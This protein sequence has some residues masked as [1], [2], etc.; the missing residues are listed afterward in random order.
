MGRELKLLARL[1]GDRPFDVLFEYQNIRPWEILRFFDDTI[2]GRN[3]AEAMLSNL[4]FSEGFQLFTAQLVPFLVLWLFCARAGRGPGL[5]PRDERWF[6]G[7]VVAGTAAVIAFKPVY[8]LVYVAFDRVAQDRG[9]VEGH[10]AADLALVERLG[11]VDAPLDPGA[12]ELRLG[13]KECGHVGQRISLL[14]GPQLPEQYG[15]LPLL[16]QEAHVDRQP[17]GAEQGTC[18]P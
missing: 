1:G 11:V 18:V 12:A 14:G 9:P 4:N 16:G 10:H 8:Y 17:L 3:H 15:E 6:H 5:L 2:L 7:A 13:D